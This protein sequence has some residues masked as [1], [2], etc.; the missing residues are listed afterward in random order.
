MDIQT[1]FADPRREVEGVWFDYKDGA[2]IKLAAMGNN[3]F[4]KELDDLLGPTGRRKLA[5]GRATFAK[6]TESMCRA[7]ARG[8][9]LDWRGF[10]NGGEPFEYS[11]E[12][13]YKLL[14]NHKQFFQ[15]I[16]EL[17][18]QEAA[19]RRED[20]ESAAGNS[21]SASDGTSATSRKKSHG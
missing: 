11:E 10:T 16:V 1:A 17:A 12:N 21:S 7:L 4:T 6:Q 3:R 14:L 13:A 20:V 15:D 8:V 19:F 5:D 2:Q 9:L 18:D